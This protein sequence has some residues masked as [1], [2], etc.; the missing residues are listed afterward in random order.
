MAQPIHQW[1]GRAAFRA[2][3]IGAVIEAIGILPAA[4]SPWGHAG[5]E[6]T[7]G[8]IS[9]AVNLPGLLA[10]Q[11]IPGSFGTGLSNALSIGGLFI[12]QTLLLGY[13]VFV[14]LRWKA[15]KG[16]GVQSNG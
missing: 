6:S 8:W 3:G 1:D 16:A 15:L 2:L 13:L 9:V 12:F 10:L 7:L 5:P 4:L 11:L 14:Y